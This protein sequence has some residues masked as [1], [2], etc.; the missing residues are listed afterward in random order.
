MAWN[1][2]RHEA[3]LSDVVAAG[4]EIGNHTM[5]HKDLAYQTPEGTKIQLQDAKTQ[6]D[7]LSGQDTKV[8]R[9]P[10]GVITGLGADIS[11][12][13]GYDILLWTA[14][15]TKP[16]GTR[17][18]VIRDYAETRFGPG[19]IL[20]LPAILES[21]P[22]QGYRFVPVSE[23]LAIGEIAPPGAHVPG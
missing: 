1:A 7:Q 9:P 11:A 2:Q 8:F 4:H 5:T 21:A 10:R 20:A 12:R 22:E 14:I 16:P 6:I 23:L 13:L 15:I 17:P 19:S 18:E 3:L